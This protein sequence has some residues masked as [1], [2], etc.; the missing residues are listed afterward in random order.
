MRLT[1]RP[2]IKMNKTLT[3]ASAFVATV[4]PKE[5]NF[6]LGRLVSKAN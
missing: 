6:T 2:S 3:A 5:F 1:A 4:C